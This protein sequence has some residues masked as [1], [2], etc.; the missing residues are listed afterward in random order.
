VGGTAPGAGNLISGNQT[1]IYL[2]GTGNTVQGNRIGTDASGTA[3]LGNSH[4]GVDVQASGN[5]IGG[6]ERRAGNV[7]AFNGNDGVSVDGASGVAILHN[8]IFANGHLGIELLNNGNNNQP[9]PTLTAAQSAGGMTTIQGTFSGQPLTTYT[10]EFFANDSAD[11]S[12]FGQGMRWLFSVVVTT[13]A[14]GNADFTVTGL[15]TVP[16]GQFV[17]ATATDPGNNTSEFSNDVP[18]TDS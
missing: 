8:A 13:D 16:V 5:L 15:G 14:S 10:L 2:G 1:G 17:T 18:V 7:I 6:T 4:D 3:A 9:A 11:P 12:G